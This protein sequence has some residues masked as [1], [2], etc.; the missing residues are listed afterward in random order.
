MKKVI[1]LWLGAFFITFLAGY[2][3]SVSS[4]DFPVSGT[5][6]FG[7]K[8][9]TYFFEKEYSDRQPYKIM[10]RTDIPEM[11]GYILRYTDAGADTIPLV[12]SQ[13]KLTAAFDS[14]APGTVLKY[15]VVLENEGKISTIPAGLTVETSVKGFIPKT[16]K[17]L[18]F[19]TLFGGVL[20]A[21]R[22]GLDYFTER[23][24]HKKNGFFA[25]IS[26]ACFSLIVTP[27]K[28]SYELGVVGSMKAITPDLLFP[29]GQLVFFVVWTITMVTAFNSK[30]SKLAAAIGAA[31]M[32]LLTVFVHH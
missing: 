21:V 2:L 8:K 30:N 25:L 27:V 3:N 15:N 10:L 22:S 9:V 5:I 12:Y 28:I 16:I 20:L 31:L 1:I 18:Y 11:R 13:N 26:L 24:N 23:K 32:L 17:V 19:L 14:V 6:G 29:A 7:K 4:P